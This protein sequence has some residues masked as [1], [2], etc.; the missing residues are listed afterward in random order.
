MATNIMR[1]D[2]L[3]SL[4]RFDPLRN[5][6]DIFREMSMIPGAQG[7]EAVPDI[8]MDVRET[9]QAYIVKAEIP[10]ANKEDIRV[11]I[12]GNTVTLQA[13]LEEE[14]SD[15]DQGGSVIRRERVFGEVYRTLTLPQDVDDAQASAKYQNGVLELTLPKKA[16]TGGKQVTVQ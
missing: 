10:G 16:G 15:Q 6:E 8:K 9:E 2:P 5:I 13:R 3:R 4:A 14:K 1:R 7:A 11:S 12:D